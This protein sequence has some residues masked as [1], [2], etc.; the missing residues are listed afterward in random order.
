[1][2]QYESSVEL[3][4]NESISVG[5]PRTRQMS[6]FVRIVLE[7]QI[8][9]APLQASIQ[10]KLSFQMLSYIEN[11]SALFNLGGECSKRRT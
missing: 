4:L 7:C 3:L 9:T 11:T 2:E 6:N 10:L 5:L 1:M 8:S